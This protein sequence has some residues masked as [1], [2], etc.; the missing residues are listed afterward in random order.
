MGD[1]IKI[2]I[3]EIGDENMYRIHLAK[4]PVAGSCEHDTEASGFIKVG[5]LLD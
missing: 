5:E 3:K 1:I 2:D 4:G